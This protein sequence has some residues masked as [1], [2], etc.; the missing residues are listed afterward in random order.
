MFFYATVTLALVLSG[1]I[2]GIFGQGLRAIFIKNS[3]FT[4]MAS[5]ENQIVTSL[6]SAEIFFFF[7]HLIF[8]APNSM[9]MNDYYYKTEIRREEQNRLT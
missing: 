5:K 7:F 9:I 2:I 8:S 6:S 1:Q 4:F 3:S